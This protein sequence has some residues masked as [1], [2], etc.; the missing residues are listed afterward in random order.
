M[1]KGNE[2]NPDIR[3]ESYEVRK[4]LDSGGGMWIRKYDVKIAFTNLETA[5]AMK[6]KITAMLQSEITPEWTFGYAE[7]FEDG[8]NHGKK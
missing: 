8:I 3:V 7:G 2:M 1:S 6:E 4:A 5:F